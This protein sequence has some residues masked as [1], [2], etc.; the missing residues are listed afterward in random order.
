MS[1]LNSLLRTLF[2][3]L[4]LPFR[5]LHPMV[6]LG[7]VS[8]I[9]SIGMLLGYK[10]TSNQDAV[11]AVKAKIAA[12]L[13]EIRLFNDDIRAIFRAQW[14]ILRHNLNYMRLNLIPMFWMMLPFVLVIAQ[15]QFHYGYEGLKVG[16]PVLMK[17]TVAESAGSTRPDVEV[18]FPEGLGAD[19][20]ISWFPAVRELAFRIVAS[21]PGSY[22]LPIRIGGETVTKTIDV[23]NNVVR[24]SPDR[25][26]P[27]FVDQLL[28]PA[29]P[30]LPADSSVTS[31]S[32]D[33]PDREV[34]LFGFETHWLIVFFILT[35]VIAFALKGRFGVT[36]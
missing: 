22:E 26:A 29:E 21:Q 30:S 28:Y 15:L 16:E 24:R 9:A 35:I 12:G 27:R 4:L 23:G 17:I 11:T 19:S 7:V 13:F 14:D 32:V 1:L 2:D 34:G 25:L 20:S 31:I 18:D 8:V 3:L 10:A 5:G 33:Y 6:G 36:I